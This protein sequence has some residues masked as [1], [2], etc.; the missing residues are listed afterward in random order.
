MRLGF[1]NADEQ[2]VETAISLKRCFPILD[3]SEEEINTPRSQEVLHLRVTRA[4]GTMAHFHFCVGLNKK[5]RVFGEVVAL[6]PLPK[7]QVMRKVF[8]SWLPSWRKQ[9]KKTGKQ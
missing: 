4:D 8:A 7:R 1:N 9:S 6:L 5:G 2:N 3:V